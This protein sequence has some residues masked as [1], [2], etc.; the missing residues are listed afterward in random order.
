[1][2][3]LGTVLLAT[4]A[5]LLWP[6]VV[7]AGDDSTEKIRSAVEGFNLQAHF[8]LPT[9]TDREMVRLLKGRLVRI[10]EVPED[11]DQPQ[12]VVG[13]QLMPH[14]KEH[15]WVAARDGHYSALEELTEAY[16]GPTPNEHHRWYQHLD[17][18]RPFAD[19]H[20]VIEVWDNYAVPEVTAGAGWEHPWE[21]T[22]GGEAM[23]AK[24]LQ[25]GEILGMGAKRARRT[26]Y[27]P[28]NRGAWV[29]ISLSDDR[30]LFGYHVTTVV[31]GNIPDG[32]VARYS[33]LTLGRVFNGT[34]DRIPYAL[35]HYDADHE[36]F[37]GGDG[38]TIPPFSP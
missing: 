2:V 29:A 26:V 22:E 5:L 4:G 19:R 17:L 9:L 14:P 32:L 18:P 24:A 35:E 31:G 1:M 6:A 30:T 37:L 34:L 10:R 38:I 12:R 8:P 16:L 3:R 23:A 15:L 13:L 25:A 7:R 27:T 36:P 33:L 21:L 20:W 28:V 11:R